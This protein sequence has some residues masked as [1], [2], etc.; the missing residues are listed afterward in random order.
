MLENI[1]GG[2]TITLT[3]FCVWTKLLN[4]KQNLKDYKLY[5]GLIVMSILI[6]LNY[7]FNGKILSLLL[8]I[9]IYT[10][11]LKFVFKVRLKNALLISIL[12][13]FLYILS[14]SFTL[15]IV[16]II[17][18]INQRTE[19]IDI[20]FGT[21]YANIL[22]SCLV[23]LL[24]RMKFVDYLY[25]KL[26][27]IV[28]KEK[29]INVFCTV[30]IL[31]LSYGLLFYSIYF[32]TN[33]TSLI[34]VCTVLIV[35]CF[36]MVTRTMTVQ[37]NYLKMYVKYNN[38]LET[39]KSY[40]DIMDKYKVSNHENKNQLL[41]IRNMLVK[42]TKDDVGKY[43]DK[44]VKNEYED[45]ENLIMETSKIPSGGLRALIYSKLLY[46]KNNHINFNLKVDKKIRSVEFA[47]IDQNIILD[48]CKVIGVFLDNAIEEVQST[49]IGSVSI[50]L[51]MLDNK[52]NISIANTFEGFI[53]LDKIDE[54]KYTTKG[55]GH[56]YGLALVKEIIEKNSSLEN[57]KKINDNVF[58]QI[59]KIDI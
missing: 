9:I 12:T 42:D 34:F 2:V 3:N 40:E 43:I 51:Y 57:V 24:G 29:F 15:V 37:N 28:E 21:I 1:I 36:I 53:D 56:G 59:L 27:L 8:V 58:I 52:L 13:Q 44:I 20:F 14:E 47:F 49:E 35:G 41:M 38:T 55:E 17:L 31:M 30:I 7:F 39:L 46:M 6:I 50:E 32:K 16:S 18:N 23:L 33:L 10:L 26:K 11:S 48:I 45:D 4:V 25:N 54:V 19:L 22:I 5:I